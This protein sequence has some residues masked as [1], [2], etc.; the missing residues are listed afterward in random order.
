MNEKANTSAVSL[1][2]NAKLAWGNEL[3]SQVRAHIGD[4]PTQ[5]AYV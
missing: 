2:D 5:D 1:Q 4:G 3:P